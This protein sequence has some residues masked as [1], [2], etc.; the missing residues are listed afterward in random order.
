MQDYWQHDSL[1]YIGK[2][3]ITYGWENTLEN[4]K[5]GYPTK[6]HTGR[7]RFKIKDISKIEEEAY[8]VMGEYYL[9]R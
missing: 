4:Y 7:L 3:G 5:K 9:S 2:N 6:A 1:M 8:F